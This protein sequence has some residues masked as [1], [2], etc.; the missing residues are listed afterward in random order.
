MNGIVGDGRFLFK[1][2]DKTF[3]KMLDILSQLL[4]KKLNLKINYEKLEK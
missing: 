1:I 3:G 2:D 4:N